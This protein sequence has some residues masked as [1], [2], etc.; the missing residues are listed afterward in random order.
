MSHALALARTRTRNLLVQIY[1]ILL[2]RVWGMDIGE[3]CVIS[4]KARLDFT[5]PHGLHI[6]DGTYLAF[7]ST[8]FTHDMSRALHG[9]T[10]VGRNCFIGARAVIMPGVTVGDHCIVGAATVVTKDVPCGSI[11]AGNPAKI[12]R[13][14]I[15]T[16][17]LGILEQRVGEPSLRSQVVSLDAASLRAKR[18]HAIREPGPADQLAGR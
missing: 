6:G 2:R 8:I 10:Y 17:K 13:S 16:R 4:L 7:D 5:N 12:I 9:D 11:V 1:P 14:D 18:R 3:G 15:R